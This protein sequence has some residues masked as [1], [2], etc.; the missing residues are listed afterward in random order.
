L[1]AIVAVCTVLFGLGVAYL[2]LRERFS[3]IN[4]WSE[5]V[6]HFWNNAVPIVAA[7]AFGFWL[8]GVLVAPHLRTSDV[9]RMRRLDLLAVVE[10]EC[11]YAFGAGPIRFDL[12]GG[13]NL[14]LYMRREAFQ[15]VDFP[16]R[17]TAV[18]TVGKRWCA[19]VPWNLMPSVAIRD[20]QTGESLAD[21]SC[22]FGDLRDAVVSGKGRRARAPN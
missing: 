13:D 12:R 6:G 7:I 10:S 14:V 21:Y 19:G 1:G 9:A 18:R 11:G 20:L 2:W 22:V 3:F 15:S 16:D 4:R 17:P 5:T 8:V